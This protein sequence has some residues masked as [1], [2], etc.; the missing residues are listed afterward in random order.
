MI[1]GMVRLRYVADLEPIPRGWFEHSVGLGHDTLG[2]YLGG[3]NLPLVDGEP[4]RPGARYATADGAVELGLESWDRHAETSGWLD[5]ADENGTLTVSV[6]LSSASAPRTVEA[7][8][9]VRAIER[10]MVGR[11]S[12]MVG[13]LWVDLERWW[14]ATSRTGGEPAIEGRVEHRLGLVLFAVRPAPTRGGRWRVT[15]TGKLRGRGV[16]RPLTAAALLVGRTKVR[17]EVATQLDAFVERWN[18]EV[19][20]LLA[21][22]PDNLRELIATALAP[23][24][25]S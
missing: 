10:G 12:S 2:E 19:P 22:R 20:A 4:L 5:T 21:R 18:R 3:P 15:V 14:T 17:H 6:R 7:N 1:R 16:L 9:Y 11:L 23:S 13:S 25:S 8:W 24:R